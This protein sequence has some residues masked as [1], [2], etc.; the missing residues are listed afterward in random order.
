MDKWL[1]LKSREIYI[2]KQPQACSNCGYLVYRF[3]QKDPTGERYKSRWYKMNLV[4]F[5]YKF[6]RDET[7]TTWTTTSGWGWIYI[8]Q[9]VRWFTLL[10]HWFSLTNRRFYRLDM[11]PSSLSHM[12]MLYIY[13]Y[14][15]IYNVAHAVNFSASS[16]RSTS[17]IPW[18]TCN[19]H[20]HPSLYNL[21][22][23]VYPSVSLAYFLCTLYPLFFILL[24]LFSL[25]RR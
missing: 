19:E 5:P 15:S 7:T 6:A 1:L 9:R 23:S 3:G 8:I 17:H 12:N 11:T 2:I 24:F 18:Q 4:E 14:L 10:C 13:I 25:T 16:N 22:Y 21:L 20:S